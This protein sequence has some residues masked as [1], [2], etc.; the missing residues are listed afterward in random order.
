MDEHELLPVTA[1]LIDHLTS[2]GLE[3]GY[4]EQTGPHT[5]NLGNSTLA[6]LAAKYGVEVHPMANAIEAAKLNS[7]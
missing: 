2:V 1:S 4:H 5:P 3:I 7:Y 6:D